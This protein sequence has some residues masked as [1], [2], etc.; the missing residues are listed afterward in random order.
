[1]SVFL[2]AMFVSLT[3]LPTL[4]QHV[5]QTALLLKMVRLNLINC[6]KKA[7][8]PLVPNNDF[9]FLN[10]IAE[11]FDQL[12]VQGEK[13]LSGFDLATVYRNKKRFR[14]IKIPA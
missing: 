14:Q 11:G 8:S 10:D 5:K 6:L 9:G 2:V 3:C 1:M 4:E 13:S 12:T 7:Q